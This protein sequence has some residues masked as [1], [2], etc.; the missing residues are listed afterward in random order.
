ME[1]S[2]AISDTVLTL[3]GIFVFLQYLR[4]INFEICLL[5]EAFILS[6][7]AASFFGVIRFLG[8]T[9][10]RLISEFFQHLAGTAGAIC[11]VFVSYLLIMSK[12][13]NKN[14]VY[15]V[16]CLG[17]SL[18]IYV[19]FT[20]NLS[21]L[22]YVSMIAIPLVLII[23]IVGLFKGKVAEGSWLIFSVLALVLAT[24]NKNFMPNTILDP[25]DI[26]HYLVAISVFCF[27]R[28]ARHQIK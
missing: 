26:Y 1:L 2:H 16:L 3:V 9:Q 22:Q 7:T 23:G 27:G 8:F 12:S 13:A 10:A 24:Y 25:I 20:D 21:V 5:W 6:I 28:A 11:L 19:T 17:F 4:K 18:F 15:V 14:T